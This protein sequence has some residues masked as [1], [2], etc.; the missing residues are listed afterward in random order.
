MYVDLIEVDLQTLQSVSHTSYSSPI[1]ALSEAGKGPLTVGTS[2][3][4]Y[5]YDP[6]SHHIRS[7]EC[8]KLSRVESR[9]EAAEFLIAP[10]SQI[11]RHIRGAVPYP[12]PLSI[13]HLPGSMDNWSD[14]NDIYVAGRF[15]SIINYDR[16]FYGR[17]RSIIHSGASLSWLT[18]IPYPFSEQATASRRHAELSMDEVRST[19]SAAGDT[20]VACGA[21]GSKGSLEL[22]GLS[23]PSDL[24]NPPGDSP[25]DSPG[26]R[27]L[28][29]CIKNRQTS[30]SSKL[31]SVAPHG[32]RL[33]FSDG[34]GNIKWVE[35]DGFTEVRH[36]N[37]QHG[38]VDVPGPRGI[39]GTLGDS[40]YMDPA[41]GDIARKILPTRRNGSPPLVN[42]DDL[43][44]WTGEKIGMLSFSGKS[45]VISADFD[46]TAESLEESHQEKAER[47]Y[48]ERM[49]HALRIQA[50]EVRLMRGLGLSHR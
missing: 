12:V 27:I 42:V 44:L 41:V 24:S 18:H 29:S 50:D 38:S 28:Q 43:L 32:S 8:P 6:R 23:S 35:R 5:V 25:G 37:I 16:R 26:G 3:K 40:Y 31:L 21:Y 48:G 14:S 39:F 2:G 4:L 45:G 10:E 11:D 33:V 9:G 7:G 49:R 46:E 36:W 17:P 1:S 15:P 30:S 47:T 20:L 34:N 13:I 22:Y 19:K